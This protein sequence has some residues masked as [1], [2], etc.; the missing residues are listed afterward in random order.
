MEYINS[1]NINTVRRQIA[2]KVDYSLPFYATQDMMNEVVNDID[3]FPY[4][5]FYRGRYQSDHP[6][7]FERETGWRVRNDNCYKIRA[8]EL[9][10]YPFHC[11]QSAC[12]TVYPCY[13]SYLRK[14][15][16]KEQLDVMLNN[17]EIVQQP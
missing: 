4:K 1:H 6:I 2:R 11:F 14:Y 5:R 9:S 3:S 15:S 10:G 7:V 16:D 8:N 17:I 12:S 13:P